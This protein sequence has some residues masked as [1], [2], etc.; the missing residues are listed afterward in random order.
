MI[1]DWLP[2]VSGLLAIA[3]GTMIALSGIRKNYANL[4]FFLFAISD[5]VW[6]IFVSLFLLFQIESLN[7]IFAE[8][9]YISA[10][11]IAYGLLWWTFTYLSVKLRPLMYFLLLAPWIAMSIV[12][13]TPGLF[14]QAIEYGSFTSVILHYSSYVMY[15]LIFAFYVILSLALILKSARTRRD[16]RTQGLAVFWSLTV[17]IAG[18]AYFNLLLPLLGD[19]SNIAYGPLFSLL[20]VGSIF[21]IIVRHGLFDIRQAVSR[22]VSYVFVLGVLAGIYYLAAYLVSAFLFGGHVSSGM[23]L[24]PINVVLALLLAF[25]FQPIKK[26]FDSITAR[27]FFHDSY[28]IDE[29]VD[30]ISRILASSVDLRS[31]LTRTSS[32][33]SE[34]LKSEGIYFVLKNK[35]RLIQIGEVKS[36]NRMTFDDAK[37][38][39]DYIT[40][41]RFKTIVD[42]DLASKRDWV[43]RHMVTYKLSI[44]VPLVNDNEVIGLIAISPHL[45]GRYT[46]RDLRLLG[47]LSNQLIVAIENAMAVQEIKTLNASLEQRISN[48]TR[49]LRRSNEQLQKLDETK[50]EFMSIASHQLRTPLTSIKGHLSMVLEGDAGSVND[51]Q[52]HLLQEA[53]TSSERMVHLIADFLNISRLNTGKFVIEKTEVDMVKLVRQEI[54]VLLPAARARNIK[55]NMKLPK[56]LPMMRLDENKVRQVVMNFAD[57]AI[58]YSNDD[59][60]VDIVLGKEGR[61]IVYTVTDKGIGVAEAD[62]PMLF[63]KFFRARNARSKRP[64]GTGVGLFLAKKVIDGHGGKIIFESTE[65]KGSTFGFSLP[66]GGRK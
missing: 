1:I 23:S 39:M 27:I 20:M 10:L 18:G 36:R 13:I 28:R 33:L 52:R 54:S 53:F 44:L 55:F 38:L 34:A 29:L 16:R 40:E 37:R 2:L 7:T 65:G 51:E 14:I 62:K 56:S 41:N 8:V 19:Y 47:T 4:A 32:R 63:H 42:N 6:S 22:T 30:E 11:L 24:S 17:S 15:S 35:T 21:Y 57:N 25:V 58:Y 46:P 66:I 48:A 3:L 59:S 64:D 31:I 60:T 45:T 26:L 43:H 12:I 61:A 5:G 50:D 49:E 9:Y